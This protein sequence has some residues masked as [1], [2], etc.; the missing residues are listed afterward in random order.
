MNV[1]LS[2][3]KNNNSDEKNFSFERYFIVLKY[4]NYSV[5][6][7]LTTVLCIDKQ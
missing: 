3:K 5:T 6:H 7:V 4:F 2:E 1:L